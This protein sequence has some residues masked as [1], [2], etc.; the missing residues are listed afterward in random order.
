MD[1]AQVRPLTGSEMEAAAEHE[2]WT[3]SLKFL[4]RVFAVVVAITGGIG[5]VTGNKSLKHACDFG[6]LLLAALG[7]FVHFTTP[8]RS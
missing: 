1:S 5:L 6:I 7:L 3:G 4:E 8:R 2:K